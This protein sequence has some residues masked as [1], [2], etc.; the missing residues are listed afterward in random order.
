MP[1]HRQFDIARHGFGR[2]LR[3]AQSVEIVFGGGLLAGQ[4]VDA[5][6]EAAQGNLL[7]GRSRPRDEVHVLG[8]LRQCFSIDGIRLAVL[9]QHLGEVVGRLRSEE[10][11]AGHPIDHHERHTGVVKGDGEV[12]VID[13][14]RFQADGDA[15]HIDPFLHQPGAVGRGVGELL[16]LVRRAVLADGENQFFRADINFGKERFE[17]LNNFFGLNDRDVYL[18]GLDSPLVQALPAYLRRHQRGGMHFWRHAQHQST[19]GGFFRGTTQFGAGRQIIF[20][21]LFKRCA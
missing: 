9:H 19:T 2:L 10:L 8:V 1:K 12:E 16:R 4:R 13:S 17:F 3:H 20:H 11:L 14:G 18:Q 6:S 21:R 15:G 5:A 7:V